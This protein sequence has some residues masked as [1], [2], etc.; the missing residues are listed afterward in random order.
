MGK[1]SQAGKTGAGLSALDRLAIQQPDLPTGPQEE[2]VAAPQQAPPPTAYPGTAQDPGVNLQEVEELPAPAQQPLEPQQQL[3]ADLQEQQRQR[4]PNLRERWAN[5]PTPAPIDSATASA[6]PDGGIIHR[7]NRMAAA[8]STGG[9]TPPVDL[10][11]TTTEGTSF[12]AAQAGATGP[13]I[14]ETIAA[15][16]EGSIQAAINRVGAVDYTNPR[17]PQI[18]P[19]FIKAGSMVTE[20]LLMQFAGGAEQVAETVADPIAAAQ[21]FEPQPEI[22]GP[23]PIKQIAKQQGNAQIGQQI[24]QE[25]QRL[26]GNEV[27][28]KI[29]PKEAET[30]GDAMKMMWAA[31]NPDLV[32]VTRDPQSN[33]KFLELTPQGEDVLA[34]GT[35]DRRRL[36]PTQ[37]VRPAK[38]P[39]KFGQLPGD[40]GE[41]QVKRVQGKVGKQAFGDVLEQSMRNLSQV[42]NVVD[43]QRLRILY[44]TALP[45]LRDLNFDTYAA[46]INNIGADKRAKYEAKH[47]PEVAQAEMR[48]A[49][50]KLAQEVQAVAQERNGANYLSYAIQGFQGRVS[51]QQSKFNPTTSKAVR[52]VTRNAVPSPAK[53]GS[54]VDYNLRQMYAMMLV[55]GADEVLPHIREQKFDAFQGQLE[56]WGDKLEAA[57]QMTDAQAEAISQAI[58]Q[59]MPL[60]DPNFPAIPELAL[61]PE[62]DAE[63]INK[64]ASKGEDGPHFIDGL[65]DAAKYVKARR[66]GQT[67]HSYFNAYIDGK[68]NGIA[69]NG[70]QMG[71][72]KTAQQTGVIRSSDTDYLDEP[73]DV[74]AVL[75]DTLLEMLDTNGF[76]GNVHE[77]SSE[78]TAVARAVFSH[79]DL[80]KKTT[81]T[82]GYGK[83]V[84]TFGKDMYETAQLL[85]TDPSLIKD[86]KMREEFIAAMPEVESR[87]E[88][89]V[90][91]GGTLMDIYG[92][93]LESVMSPEALATRSIMRGA[94]VLHAATNSLMSIKGPTGMDLNF[95]RET[96]VAEGVTESAY[97]LRGSEIEGGEQQFR[98]IHQEKEA[99]SAAARTYTQ[100]DQ[101]TGKEV[102]VAQAGDYAYGGSVV[103]P[104]QA[105]DAATVG[106]TTAGKSWNRLKQASGNNPYIH[107]IYDAFKADAMGFDV[108]LEEVNQNWLDASMNWSYLEETKQSTQDTMA[109]WKKNVA[110]RNP[111]E[112]LTQN[113]RA[114]MDFILKPETN[115]EGKPSMKNYYKK[116]GTAGN[117]GKRG[118]KPFD[119]MKEMAGEM[120]KVGYDWM[121]PPA[122]PTVRQLRTFVGVLEKQLLMNTRFDKAINFTN[123]NKKELRKE[124][125]EKGYKTRSGRTIPLQY[126]AH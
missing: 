53:P 100:E 42:P 15:E 89:E 125:M 76:D 92:P 105:I 5:V 62:A 126:Y 54:R 94:A 63:L 73:G 41:T 14:A 52:F 79:R 9:L 60:N 93:A 117:F 86:P 81:M 115:V 18:D 119:M 21:G 83:E 87:L 20:N 28:N 45:T 51:P 66:N 59:G 29:P 32:N 38:I 34:K 1:F 47:G 6:K 46:K 84:D 95:G 64:I 49:A 116:I 98:A 26:K 102:T 104:V 30:L 40:T 111:N 7:A 75:K 82:F 17:A 101:F 55:P 107:T 96:R 65:I 24:A 3:E 97:R 68:T 120:R 27:P 70:I 2:T 114:Y 12:Q 10:R 4:V 90:N 71:N 48:K 25:Y 74:R 69:S 108:V 112:T 19:D 39:L 56:A 85:K 121:D 31:Q 91:F 109:D 44:A 61:D 57:L 43:K 13:Q 124:I 106:L 8:V 11:G 110:Q 22:G 113:E 123:K 33:Q 103:G 23:K 67:H 35:G 50:H 122:E 78:L 77:Y 16:K 80:N 72:S 58:E 36:F 88:G 37:Q 99:T 118:L